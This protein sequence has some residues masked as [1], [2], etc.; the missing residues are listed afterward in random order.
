M[1]L[2]IDPTTIQYP[3]DAADIQALIDNYNVQSYL[4]VHG[5]SKRDAGHS[6]REKLL[7]DGVLLNRAITP[8]IFRLIEE[9]FTTLHLTD[10]FE[11]FAVKN[12]DLN[13]F[14]DLDHEQATPVRLIA[15]T[16]A[17]LESLDDGEIRFLIG[18]E[19][20][21]HLFHHSDL[22][23]LFNTDPDNPRLTVLPY[24]GECLFLRWRKKAELSADRIGL[25]A[26][27]SF[28]DAAGALIKSGY[29]LSGK[30]LNLDLQSLL[31]QIESIR[32]SPELV[33]A[34]FRSHPLLPLRLEAL[35]LF[36]AA[37]ESGWNGSADSAEREIDR[38][39]HILRRHPRKPLDLA[40]MRTVA[41]A[42]LELLAAEREIVDEEV[43]T[44]VYVLHRF[45][46]DEPE[47]ELTVALQDRGAR[48]AEALAE[49]KR[50]GDD[51]HALFVISR[52]ADLALADGKLLQAE[53][54]V[55]LEIAQQLGLQPRK[56]YEVMMA[57]AQQV[58]FNFDT[59][60][61]HLVRRI[62]EQMVLQLQP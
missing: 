36:H 21:H 32:E 37:W 44:L 30:N 17:A 46:T 8:R 40:V 56:A 62:K 52:L 26:A 61:Q 57:A 7:K 55:I 24:L 39:F 35:R 51:S 58:G 41:L 13:A 59:Q 60:M 11:V 18:H 14:A 22:M 42:G 9:V 33:E 20:G 31:G 10:P 27:G 3:G 34:T 43:R 48:L 2:A 5:A 28:Q 38:L 23:G 54:G 49:V 19:L 15:I 47:V 4:Q 29:G 12:Q 45:F 1:H 25:I 50:L 53:A 6:P 16:S